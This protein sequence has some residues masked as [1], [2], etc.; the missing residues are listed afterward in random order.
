MI[1]TELSIVGIV[2]IVNFFLGLIVYLRNPQSWTNRFFLMLTLLIALYAVVHYLSLHPPIDIL[3][4]QLFWIRADMAVGAF[5]GPLLFLLVYVFPQS[6][7]ELPK[8]YL[9][10]VLGLAVTTAALSFTPF[11]FKALEFPNGTPL[12]IPGSGIF[13]YFIDFIGLIL[14]SFA[15][16]IVKYRRSTGVEKARHLY[17]LLGV[18]ATFTVMVITTLVFVVILKTS[19]AVFLGPVST[20]ILGAFVAYAIVRHQFLDIKPTIMRIVSFAV[21]LAVLA[22]LYTVLFMFGFHQLFG[23]TLPL[24]VSVGIFVIAVV[25]MLSFQSVLS[26]IRRTTDKFFFKGYYDT[27]KLMSRLTH[28]M[29]ETI[30]LDVLASDTLD[31]ILKEIRISKGAFLFVDNDVVTELRGIGYKNKRDFLSSKF[32]SLFSDKATSGKVVMFENLKEGSLKD[33]FRKLDIF[34]AIPVSVKGDRV[35]I[36][37]LGPK[38]SGEMYYGRDVHILEL[39][40]SEAGIA[41][42]NAK[43][44]S[45]IKQFSAQLEKKVEER[46]KELKE[47]QRQEIEKAREVAKL[48]DEFVFLAAHEL[49]SPVAAIR[50]FIDLTKGSQA[51]FPKDVQENFSSIA[52][53]SDHLRHLVDDIL[54]VA[55]N[56]GGAGSAN[57][58]PENF[59]PILDEVLHEVAPLIKQKNITLTVDEKLTAPVMS[60]RVKLKEVLMNLID[61]AIKYNRENG[62]VHIG[63]YGEPTDGEMIVEIA[64]TG[65]GIPKDQQKHIFEKFFRATS[66][67]TKDVLGTGLGLFI[68]R[69]LIEKMSGTLLFSSVP[70][71]GTTFSFRLPLFYDKDKRG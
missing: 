9:Y 13:L 43:S 2:L 53:A 20:T 63:I 24:P 4:D 41:I 3:G 8:K 71:E 66:D 26:M 23:V 25:A 7:F 29:A 27:D 57:M 69:V 1:S 51:T 47:S 70:Q 42:Q 56:E 68:T 46:T 60:D 55:R 17:F 39:F 5:I 48:K 52:E 61:N 58:K 14:L 18:S 54:Q 10:G 31:I 6:V 65:Y 30:D 67:E 15:L 62:T 34:I 21:F 45:Q 12:P 49:R 38:L 37:I 22:S 28:V 16:L 19:V 32:Q 40:A 36:L 44:Y 59:R 64:D 35:A 11:I 33:F 50:G